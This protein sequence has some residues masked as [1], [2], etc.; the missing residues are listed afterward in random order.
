M[1]RYR[2]L[3]IGGGVFF[4]TLALAQRGSNLLVQH[5][6]RLRRVY[7]AVENRR[8]FET[9]AICIL[10]DHIHAL[11]QLPDGDADYALRWSL[12][13]P[14]FSRGLPPRRRSMSK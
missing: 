9:V 10:P 12:F 7:A 4:F 8:P 2:R 14:G 13:K 5:I 11:W 3:K 1:S 6:E